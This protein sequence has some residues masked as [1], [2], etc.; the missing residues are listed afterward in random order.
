MYEHCSD[1]ADTARDAAP[2]FSSRHLQHTPPR[3]TPESRPTGF[4]Q[5][6]PW[7]SP[8]RHGLYWDAFW[9]ASGSLGF[10]V[11]RAF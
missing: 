9:E 11:V 10:G 6:A 5:L 7:K 3:V 1:A 4:V 8:F 2:G